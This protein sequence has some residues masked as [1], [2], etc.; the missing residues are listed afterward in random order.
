[1]DRLVSGSKFSNKID[2]LSGLL[3]FPTTLSR[4]YSFSQMMIFGFYNFIL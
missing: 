1:M 3:I 2:G 4:I